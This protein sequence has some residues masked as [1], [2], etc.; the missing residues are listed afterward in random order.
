MKKLT[1]FHLE[2]CPYC[3]SARRALEALRAEDPAFAAV[4]V[5]W[6]EESRQ[7]ERT[8]GMD[9]Y[10]VPSVFMDGQKLYEAHPGDTDAV[11][12][13]RMRAALDAAR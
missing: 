6:V 5:E 9:Y 2:N 10:Y 12:M 1:I 11:I 13:S 3:H 4:P 7:P 8:R